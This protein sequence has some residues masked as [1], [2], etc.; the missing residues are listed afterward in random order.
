[1]FQPRFMCIAHTWAQAHTEQKNAHTRTQTYISQ[2]NTGTHS[3][4]DTSSSL[5]K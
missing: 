4:T 5:A 1:M 3:Q 2:L